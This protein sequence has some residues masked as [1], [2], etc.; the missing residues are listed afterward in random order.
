V[1]DPVLVAGRYQVI[2]PLGRGTFARTLLARDVR[3]DRQVA[4]KVLHPR[5]GD[6]LKAYELFE[7]EAAVLREL[8]HPGVPAIHTTLRADYE[9][10]EA[11]FLV[12]EYI[13]GSSLAELISDRRHLEPTQVIHLFDELLG[14]LDYLHSRVPPVLH[15]DIKPANLIVRPDGS[16][17]LVDFGAVRNVFRSPDDGGSTV[18]GTYGY[19]PYEQYMGQASP[20]SDL[21]A[22]GATFLHLLTGRSPPDFMGTSGRLEVPATIPCG[23]ALRGV[24]IRLLAPAQSERYQSA[25]E[26]RAALLSGGT[27]AAPAPA[28]IIAPPVGTALAPRVPMVPIELGPVPRRLEGRVDEVYRKVR[29]SPWE[30]MNTSIRGSNEYGVLDVLFL[31][32][33]SVITVGI[34]PA[35]FW[36]IY[37][38]RK[39][40]VKSFMIHG[41]PAV[42]RVLDMSNEKTA[43]DEKLTKV[44]YEF[45]A[46]G[47]LRRGSDQVLPAI[48]ERWERGD[49]IQV[50]YR[51]ERDFDSIIITTG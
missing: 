28:A 37:S 50:L 24:L 9:G 16:P 42:G 2:R 6:D 12:M 20:S 22:V 19:M 7:R 46:E 39:R 15:R 31:V 51:P 17:V 4:L 14:I 5:G 8:R 18:V 40:R 47:H 43:F 30:L 49:P 48:A 25:R 45:E 21:Y 41:L 1:P 27:G 34:L 44:R 23:E 29:Y 33:F 13:E 38:T 32:F 11:A 36:S 26:A 3:L 35:V 10:A